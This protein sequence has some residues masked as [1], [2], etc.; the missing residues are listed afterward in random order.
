M[1]TL[2]DLQ[3][4]IIINEIQYK[5]N[6]FFILRVLAD[7]ENIKFLVLGS[8][9]KDL[10]KQS[11]ETLVGRIGY[12]E[13]TP[14]EIS[15]ISNTNQLWLCGGFSLSYLAKSDELSFMVT[16]LYPNLFRERYT[17]FGIL[18]TCNAVT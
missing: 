7:R 11:S 16:K 8:A 10:T 12:I 2:S 4:F 13:M 5:P 14:F 1:L 17:K 9:S 18:N 3:G 15:E 6:L